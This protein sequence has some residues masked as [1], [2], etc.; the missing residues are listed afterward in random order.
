[1]DTL[2]P[3]GF[4]IGCGDAGSGRP[5]V[6]LH[7]SGTDRHVWNKVMEVWSGMDNV[8]P[9]R[10]LRPELFGCGKT[11]R[12]P[13]GSS[14][15]LDDVV[16]LVCRAL[17]DIEEPFDLVGH[18]FGGATA[19]HF[20][21]RMPQRLRSL[22]LIEPTYFSL[23]QDLGAAEA[24]LFDEVAGVARVI[25]EGALSGSEQGRRHGFGVFVDYW[26]GDGKW[27]SVPEEAQKQMAASVDVI[28]L[29]FTALFAEATRLHDLRGLHVPTMLVNGLRSPKPVQH[30]AAM[31]EAVL[32]NAERHTLPDAGHMI[33]LSHAAQLAGL[34]A[35]RQLVNKTD[36]MP[37]CGAV[38]ARADG[39]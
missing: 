12:W 14:F 22:T 32:P 28:T 13:A 2:L 19:L 27:Q 21:R 6:L 38:L 26:N 24:A 5:L 31:L 4:P 36:V 34:I 20:A 9:R 10:I 29:D 39:V 35:A 1:M 37:G 11:A 8:P 25:L 33:P 7:C 17:D 18:S 16:D 15:R 3:S 30:I 23:L